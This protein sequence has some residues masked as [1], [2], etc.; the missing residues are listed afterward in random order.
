MFSRADRTGFRPIGNFWHTDCAI[1]EIGLAQLAQLA[2]FK[3]YIVAA[4]N[5]MAGTDSYILTGCGSWAGGGR[6]K[7]ALERVPVKKLHEL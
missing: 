5:K 6:K 2:W 4:W 1:Q 7:A 3:K